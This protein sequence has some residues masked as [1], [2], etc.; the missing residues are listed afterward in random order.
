MLLGDKDADKK[1][2]MTFFYSDFQKAFDNLS[3][4]I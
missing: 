3:H 2:T 1:V 4:Q